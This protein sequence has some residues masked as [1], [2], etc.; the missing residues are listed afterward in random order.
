MRVDSVKIGE[1]PRFGTRPFVVA[2]EIRASLKILPLLSKRVE[3]EG[4]QINEPEIELIRKNGVWN[5][6]SVGGPK[7]GSGSSS[8]RRSSSARSKFATLSQP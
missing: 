4:V 7:S 5:Y 8:S 2:K 1:D 6:E 3:I